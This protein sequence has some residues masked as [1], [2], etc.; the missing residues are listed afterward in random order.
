MISEHPVQYLFSLQDFALGF[1]QM[2]EN[3]K[4]LNREA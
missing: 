1:K 3:I 4:N 2:L